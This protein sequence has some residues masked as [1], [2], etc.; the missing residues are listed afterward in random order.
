VSDDGEKPGFINSVVEIYLGRQGQAVQLAHRQ[1][2]LV[3]PRGQWWDPAKGVDP[4]VHNDPGYSS[5]WGPEDAHPN[6]K[7]GK[8]WLLPYNTHKDPNE[9]HQDASTWYDE[10][11]V[12]RTRPADPGGAA[13]PSG[14][15]VNLSASPTSLAAG[16]TSTLT[17]SSSNATAC[18]A[19]GAWS[20]AKAVSGTQSTGAL[21]ATSTYTLTCTGSSGASSSRSVTV[22]VQGSTPAPTVNLTASPATVASGGTSTLNW[23]TSGATACTASGG[24]SGWAGTKPLS[25]SANVGPF[26][27]NSTFTLSCTGP[28]GTTQGSATVSLTAA[29]TLTL[30]ADPTSVAS[31]G[32]STLTWTS[33]GSTGCT[34]SN[35]WA[36][37]KAATG[38]EQ[39]AALTQATTFGMQ[40]TGA[41]G[42][43]TK[44]VTVNISSTGSTPSPTPSPTPAPTDPNTPPPTTGD[45]TDS[46]GGGAF[47]WLTLGALLLGAG[48]RRRV[49]GNRGAVA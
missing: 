25:G 2:G 4:D 27:A 18:T 28:G 9:A 3:I 37:T 40:C 33:T 32:K 47:E 29:P 36:G 8:I 11:I 46:S 13:A 19:S 30:T 42:S 44:S 38:S 17:W 6:A 7:Y 16:A 23:T 22:S 20:G 10:L 14:P 45:Q 43:V 31:G 26:T 49:F 41:G 15:S 1:E 21:N 34:A 39:T 24:L 12:S 5:G 48:V 35:G